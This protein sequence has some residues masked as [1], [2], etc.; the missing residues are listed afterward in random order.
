M[1]PRLLIPLR[2][3][4]IIVTLAIIVLALVLYCEAAWGQIPPLPQPLTN[5]VHRVFAPPHPSS[6]RLSW[7]Y[8]YLNFPVESSTNGGA[9]WQRETNVCDFEISVTV[10]NNADFKLYRAGGPTY[11]GPWWDVPMTNDIVINTTNNTI[12]ETNSP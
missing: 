10:S 1:I 3:W 8:D 4:Q 9:S 7:R 2:R 11:S 6:L 12:V 5:I